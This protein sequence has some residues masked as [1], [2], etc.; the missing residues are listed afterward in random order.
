MSRLRVVARGGSGLDFTKPSWQGFA[1]G[2]MPCRPGPGAR[3]GCPEPAPPQ[4]RRSGLQPDFAALLVPGVRGR[5]RCAPAAL[6]SDSARESVH[7]A[8]CARHPRACGARRRLMGRRRLRAA[9][10][11]ARRFGMP[12]RGD[13]RADLGWVENMRYCRRSAA[14]AA[15]G[16]RTRQRQCCMQ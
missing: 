16:G 1:P 4:R 7:E 14:L 2:T 13:A 15:S 6:R 12:T 9:A 10:P 5:T 8:R 3:N 11:R